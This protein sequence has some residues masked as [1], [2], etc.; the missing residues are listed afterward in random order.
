MQLPRTPPRPSISKI[1]RSSSVDV[2]TV[3]DVDEEDDVVPIDNGVLQGKLPALLQPPML[4]GSYDN[5][6][7]FIA[8][9]QLF[10]YASEYIFTL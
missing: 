4:A 1:I 9:I 5:C 2:L 8:L 10:D 6:T 3:D 7:F